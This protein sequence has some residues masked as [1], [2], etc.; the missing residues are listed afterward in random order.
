M[1]RAQYSK[2]QEIRK[3]S[4]KKITHKIDIE[5]LNTSITFWQTVLFSHNLPYR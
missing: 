3:S 2:I 4:N 5:I 1:K